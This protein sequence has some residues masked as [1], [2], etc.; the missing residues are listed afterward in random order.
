LDGEYTRTACGGGIH[1]IPIL[2]G[3]KFQGCNHHNTAISFN[4]KV[5]LATVPT[6]ALGLA[7]HDEPSF[8]GNSLMAVCAS[9]NSA[10]LMMVPFLDAR[11]VEEVHV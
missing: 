3:V 1:Y 10:C 4:K 5:F 8:E 9:S 2:A 11:L 7:N 6:L